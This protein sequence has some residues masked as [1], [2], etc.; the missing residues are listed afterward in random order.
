MQLID[1]LEWLGQDKD[2]ILN[3]I[4]FVQNIIKISWKQ[5]LYRIF[6]LLLML[7]NMLAAS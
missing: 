3:Q 4:N 6:S 5:T 1:E 7:T 2:W